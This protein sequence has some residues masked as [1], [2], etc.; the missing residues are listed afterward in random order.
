[1]TGTRRS[2]REFIKALSAGAAGLTLSGCFR[3]SSGGRPNLLLITADDMNYDSPG[4]CG[5]PVP[6]I[7]PR[8]D[9][10]AA[11]GMIFEQA[12]V[13]IAVCQPCRQTLL[14]GRT[15]IRHG[16]EGFHPI[17]DD[18]PTLVEEVKRAGY[19]S[20]I[21]GKEKH[22]KPDSKFTWDFVAGENDVASG[23]GIGR[24][25]EKYHDFA[26]EFLK[27][28]RQTGK[29]FFLSANAHDPHRPFAGSESEKRS[30]GEAL[31]RVDR[32][33]RP[34]EVK[35][36]GFLPDI[37]DVRTEIAQYMTSV[38][39]CDR[40]VGA[41]LDALEEGGFAGSTLVLF[42]SDNGMSF[43]FAKANCYL[44]STKTPWI[45]RWPGRIKAGA[46][47]GEAMV[48]TVDVMPTF[49]EAAGIRPPEGMDGR[50]FLS[51]LTGGGG[52]TGDGVF[53]EF[54]ETSARKRYPMRAV[55]TRRFGYIVNFW[56]DGRTEMTMDST[57]GMTF[58]AMREA[59]ASDPEIARR[60]T[61]FSKQVREELYDFAADPDGLHNLIDDPRF[62]EEIGRLR[63]RLED[64]LARTGDPALEAFRR[65]NDPE[66][67]A[68]FMEEQRERSNSLLERARRTTG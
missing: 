18:V 11:E 39:R 38:H 25:P 58:R 49:L 63:S 35:V 37:P 42:L 26:L 32:W 41:V 12:H 14:T 40:V 44:S 65:R 62:A 9:R 67:A 6:G 52:W 27:R 68:A 34:D 47:N 55:L 2:R 15:P 21:L 24:S 16:G 46:R 28:A 51:L 3:Q 30:W 20:G 60:V 1:M 56:A 13:N 31:P 64:H 48:S 7:T 22:Y 61:L 50:S 17:L 23:L 54:H 4:F 29:P 36:P 59:A 53:T 45:V 66:A 33:I 43:P 5:N 10:L 57:G 8:I 19:L